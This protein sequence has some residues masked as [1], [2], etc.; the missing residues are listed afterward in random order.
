M[1][2]TNITELKPTKRQAKLLKEMLVLAG[3]VWN[4]ANY[5]LRQ[6]FFQKHKIN[7][8][9]ALLQ[10]VNQ[11]S[12]VY[13]TLGRSYALPLLHKLDETWRS[14]KNL[15]REFEKGKTDKP[16][17]PHY[18]KD[19][20]LNITL[21]A[22]LV[23]DSLQYHIKRRKVHL[24]ISRAMRKQ[25]VHQLNI[26]FDGKPRW[27]GNQLRGELHYNKTTKK[28]YLCQAIDVPD[29]K[30]KEGETVAIDLGIKRPIV[31]YNGEKAVIYKFHKTQQDWENLTGEITRLQSIA[32]SRNGINTTRRIDNLSLKRSR[33]LEQRFNFIVKDLIRK[34]P[35]AGT[36]IVGDL[37]N[38]RKRVPG[39]CRKAR[40]MINNY[41]SCAKLVRKLANK[42]QE[43]G[44]TFAKRD[45]RSTTKTCPVCGEKNKPADRSYECFFCGY[46]QDR[47]VVGAINIWRRYV[48]TGSRLRPALTEVMV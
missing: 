16:S 6:E 40:R 41:W 28:F 12:E 19:R 25:G 46:R 27:G 5:Q 33:Q 7:S 15:F 13:Q 44:A 48:S 2:R 29:P 43:I 30:L 22:F 42:A 39:S 35:D 1:K 34:F 36:F 9:H 37:T 8:S 32:K 24:P 14:F 18:F 11:K 38:I 26:R 4:Q 20:K 23:F 31:A 10:R 47:D 21:P 45:E 3:A 17:P